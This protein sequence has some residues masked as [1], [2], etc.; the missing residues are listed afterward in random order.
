VHGGPVPSTGSLEL[1]DRETIIS[2]LEEFVP[3]AGRDAK[4]LIE[5]RE[6]LGP[7]Y[8]R[9]FKAANVMDLKRANRNGS[10]QIGE[11][12][13]RRESVPH[14]REEFWVALKVDKGDRIFR[15]SGWYR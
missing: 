9:G 1:G 6:I 12:P 15:W 13:R 10:V 7:R 11:G 4:A 5:T 14:I 2:I 3:Y 8:E